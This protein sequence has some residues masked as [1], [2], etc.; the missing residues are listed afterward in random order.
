LVVGDAAD[1][2]VELARDP[3][4]RDQFVGNVRLCY[5]DPPFNTGESF[6]HY[7]DS[8]DPVLW[9]ES[10]RRVLLRL[11]QFLA[12]DASIWFHIDD[13]NQHIARLILDEVFGRDSFIATVFWQKRTTRDNR[14]AF[15]SMHDYLHVYA[16]CG[17]TAWKR[18]RNPL[19]NLGTFTH[20]DDVRGPWRSVPLSVQAG[21]GTP[22]QFYSIRSPLGD[23]HDPP[24]GRCWAYSQARFAELVEDD[25]IHWPR[26]GRGRPRLKR[27]ESEITG[28]APFTIWTAKE[29][30]DN[31]AAKRD[32]L[33][34]F[35]GI[36]P[37]DTPK[38]LALL[39]RIISIATNPGDLVLDCYL[40]SG[41][42]AVAAGRL[43]R[44]WIGIELESRVI[45]TFT[46]PRLAAAD[47]AGGYDVLEVSG[48]NESASID[49]AA[50]QGVVA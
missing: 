36:V 13:A 45:S 34:S 7:A 50:V 29:V 49:G 17:A 5:L 42:T 38:P 6:A 1:T 22:S 35:P 3:K 12:T 43:G 8:K 27:Y 37:F 11:R 46:M 41:T 25:R 28:L 40:G 31:G 2:L 15:S 4:Y 14:T 47:G 21:H 10:I 44:R 19:P 23:I 26:G 32:L 33:A 24:N 18:S 16:P 20:R 48:N 9:E 30:G 39:D